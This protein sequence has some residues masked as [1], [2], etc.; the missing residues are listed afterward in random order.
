MEKILK[1][2]KEPKILNQKKA[3]E[4]I[5]K[6]KEHNKK[7]KIEVIDKLSTLITAGFGLV[8]AL[9]WNDAIKSIVAKVF[10][11]PGDQI[12]AMVIYALIITLVA[13]L[14]TVW[15]SRIAQKVKE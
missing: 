12:T 2:I 13:V 5:S 8:A 10:G 4:I 11:S 15:I 9:A 1:K 6:V 14:A 7:L 3:K